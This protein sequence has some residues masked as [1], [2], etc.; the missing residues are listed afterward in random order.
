MEVGIQWIDYYRDVR[1]EE[2]DGIIQ[3]IDSWVLEQ[4]PIIL[5]PGEYHEVKQREL[6]QGEWNM[7]EDKRDYWPIR[8]AKG[9]S[10]EQSERF[11]RFVPSGNGLNPDF[12]RYMQLQVTWTKVG[13]EI[14]SQ[15]YGRRPDYK[16][17]M[18]IVEGFA[19]EFRV[20]YAL[21]EVALKQKIDYPWAGQLRRR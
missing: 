4:R 11:K 17:Q 9:V 5:S 8:I 7:I 13:A 15:K 19:D 3:R 21:R 20:Y 2:Q 16:E 18:E 1:N 14:F 10:K 6:T 12:M